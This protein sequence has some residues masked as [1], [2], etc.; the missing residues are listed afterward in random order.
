[1]RKRQRV[2][3]VD[4]TRKITHEMPNFPGEPRPG[5]IHFGDLADIGFRCKQVLMP[6]HFGTHTDAY[7]HFL[8][9]GAS[10]DRI[11][12]AHYVGP[13]VV[14]DVRRRPDRARVTRRDLE[15]AWPV[16]ATARRVLV[17]TGWGERVK[18]AA[19]FKNFPGIEA[20][21]ARWLIRRKI[22][23]LGLDLPSVHP[24]EYKR[25]HELLFN[26]GIAVTEGLINLSRLPR[27]EVFFAGLPLALAGLDGSPIRA[28]AIV[29]D[30]NQM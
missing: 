28:I 25:V 26:A 18:G 9:G 6:T 21:T 19:F 29:G 14:L 3:V 24:K 16:G 8:P 4:L 2:R 5:F 17:N 15:A 11:P 22:I 30:P 7:S 20:E 12:P 1:M 13:A 23:M 10:I 27:G